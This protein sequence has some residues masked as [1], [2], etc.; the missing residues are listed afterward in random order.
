MPAWLRKA[1][2]REVTKDRLPDSERFAQLLTI[3][4]TVVFL[5]FFFIHQSRPTGFFTDDF[6]A[7]EAALF[8]GVIV[9]GL[10]PAFVRLLTGRKNSGRPFDIMQMAFFAVAGAYL[11]SEFP[12]DFHHFADALPSYLQ[13]TIDWMTDGIAKFVMAIALIAVVVSIP[14]NLLM[15]VFVGQRL[16]SEGMCCRG[17]PPT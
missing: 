10:V 9:L 11:L 16:P 5:W 17:S 6:G 14:W 13:P 7:L 4:M 12:F 3:P 2:E 8:Y 15:Y 1:V